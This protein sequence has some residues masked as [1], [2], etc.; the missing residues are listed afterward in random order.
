MNLGSILNSRNAKCVA[1]TFVARQT[2]ALNAERFRS[3]VHFV[4]DLP[5]EA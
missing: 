3:Q 1:M 2:A 5:S 4:I